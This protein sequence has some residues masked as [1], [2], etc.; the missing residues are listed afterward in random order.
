MNESCLLSKTIRCRTNETFSPPRSPNSESMHD[1]PF[2]AIPSQIDCI[3]S[4]TTTYTTPRTKS[5]KSIQQRYS[6]L[7]LPHLSLSSNNNSNNNNNNNEDLSNLATS[8]FPTSPEDQV[9]QASIAL[10]LANKDNKTRHSIRLLLPIIGATE[11]DDWSGGARQMMDAASP[12]IYDVS[13][14]CY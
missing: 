1:G 7:L 9:R 2:L 12:L 14:K 8:R 3:P 10:A 4:T 5:P 6:S 13:R 11:L